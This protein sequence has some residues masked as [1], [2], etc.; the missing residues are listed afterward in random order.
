MQKTQKNILLNNTKTKIIHL[1]QLGY[2]IKKG[3]ESSD[4][5]QNPGLRMVTLF[6]GWPVQSNT[7]MTCLWSTE[8]WLLKKQNKLRL[9]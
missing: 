4:I 2:E 3:T 7:I 1:Q 6:P 8:K 5:V 9:T